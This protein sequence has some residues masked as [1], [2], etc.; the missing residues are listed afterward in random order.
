MSSQTELRRREV[1]RAIVD[2]LRRVAGTGGLEG[3]RD[4][5]NLGVSSA[6]IPQ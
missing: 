6:T 2:R 4:K 1:L 3:A 5:H